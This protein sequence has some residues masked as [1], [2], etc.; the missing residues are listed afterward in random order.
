MSVSRLMHLLET[1]HYRLCLEEAL[2]LLS[3][4]AVHS[5]DQARVHAAVCRCRLE[6]GDCRAAIAAGLQALSHSDEGSAPDLHGAVLID[7][8]T[9]WAKLRQYN[10]AL[11]AWERF[12]GLL[13][14]LTGLICQEGLVRLQMAET[15]QRLGHTDRALEAY[16]AGRRW[17]ERFGDEQSVRTCAR[18]M[19]GIY[20]ECGDLSAALPLL[21]EGDLHMPDA[22]PL[23]RSCQLLDW[24]RYLLAAGCPV[25]AA[26]RAFAALELAPGLAEQGRAQMVL[27]QTA[28][29][30]AK[31]VEA[32]AFALAARISA[33]EGNLYGL[34]FDAAEVIFRLLRHHGSEL[35]AEVAADFK[36]Q[37]VDIYDY[38][39]ELAVRRCVT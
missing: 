11:G 34:E 5:V 24:A 30:Q 6:L 23:F 4:G 7:M 25:L 37:G 38:L 15:L 32:L 9:A 20:L 29:Q 31:P 8:G 28:L 3:A 33:M 17:F 22:G 27:C 12:I 39:S 14:R 1:G 13:P 26:E 10:T 19:I 16:E 21:K 35:L 18:G 36:S 2:A